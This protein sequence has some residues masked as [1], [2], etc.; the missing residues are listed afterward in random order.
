MYLNL[1]RKEDVAMKRF[2][3]T[4]ISIISLGMLFSV[5]SC[6]GIGF[7]GVPG[8]DGT[9]D[10]NPQQLAFYLTEDN[11]YH[12]G[13]GNSTFL[14]SIV[15]PS[16]YKGLPVTGI[17]DK[18]F[19]NINFNRSKLKT[20]YIPDSV[21][22]IGKSAFFHCYSLT[23]ITIP[24]SVTSIGEYAFYDCSSLSYN[25]FNNALYV[26]NDSNPYLF[27]IKAIDKDV[28]AFEISDKCKFIGPQAFSDCTSLKSITI[29]DSVTSIGVLAFEYC[30]SLTSI[31][32][33]DSVTSIDGAFS[34]CTSLTSITIPDSVTS[35]DGAF[36]GCSSLTSITIPNS[37]ASI[38][39]SAF[40]DCSSL[41]SITI[42]DSVTS[43]G[44][45]AFSGCSS[46]TSITIPD[47]VTSIYE[48][49]F[50]HCE[51]LLSITYS[52]TMNQWNKIYKENSWYSSDDLKYI[53]CVD[54][55]IKL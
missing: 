39:D 7:Q 43:I 34:G 55:I 15:I 19:Y 8:K 33:P 27:L 20:I 36:R 21:T 38:G 3:K 22:S 11:T 35:I 48:Y 50:Y 32:I 13:Q 14:S 45:Y 18:G 24:D 49:A 10:D 26:G 9:S 54:G 17:A 40:Y 44:G 51:S 29:P 31:T 37:L 4:F 6:G 25:E 46:L 42:P 23:S 53:V 47:S 41:T 30:T 28:N 52:G 12:V 1:F 16:S 2:S 5:T